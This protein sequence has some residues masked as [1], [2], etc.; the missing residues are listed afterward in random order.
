MNFIQTNPANRCLND[1]EDYHSLLMN[2][3]PVNLLKK[4]QKCKSVIHCVMP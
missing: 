3:M 2:L 1:T 4:L